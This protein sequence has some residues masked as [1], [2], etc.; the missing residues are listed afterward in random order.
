M[1]AEASAPDVVATPEAV[2]AAK[3]EEA[4]EAE[5]AVEITTGHSAQA[6]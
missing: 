1:K 6:K 3:V 2:I 5:A 4:R